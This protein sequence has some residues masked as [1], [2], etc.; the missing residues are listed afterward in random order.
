MRPFLSFSFVSP[1]FSRKTKKIKQKQS[2]SERERR[3]FECVKVGR[4][5]VPGFDAFL[6]HLVDHA[7]V[8]TILISRCEQEKA[9]F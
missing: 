5:V 8:C 3:R 4:K 9:L 2:Q 7:I 1:D 6:L